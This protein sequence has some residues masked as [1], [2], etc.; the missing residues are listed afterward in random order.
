MK[1]FFCSFPQ[2]FSWQ[3]SWKSACVQHNY[4]SSI[5]T[6]RCQCKMNFLIIFSGTTRRK[7]FCI[8]SDL[9]SISCLLFCSSS[10][11]SLPSVFGSSKPSETG[12][13]LGVAVQL[14]SVLSF[15][16]LLFFVCLFFLIAFK[17]WT[18]KK[19]KES[20]FNFSIVLKSEVAGTTI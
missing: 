17:E 5:K 10:F 1:S 18:V 14:P 9:I 13:W 6:V 12:R 8:F 20:P 16:L 2:N 3:I 7:T 15:L 4:N 11:W 19:L